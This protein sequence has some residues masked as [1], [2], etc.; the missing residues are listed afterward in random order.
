M[1]GE[2]DYLAINDFGAKWV[3]DPSSYDQILLNE[4]SKVVSNIC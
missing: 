2:C 4:E 1:G 3:K